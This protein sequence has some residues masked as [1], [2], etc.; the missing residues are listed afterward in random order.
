ME[1]FLGKL[2][3]SMKWFLGTIIA[4]IMFYLWTLID[5]SGST[6]IIN[7]FLD[8]IKS[9]FGLILTVIIVIVGLR[10][11]LGHRPW[12]LGGGRRGGGH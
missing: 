11:M 1:E 6:V 8:F 2:S 10:I 12:W 9:L 4:V 5:P 3:T 7:G